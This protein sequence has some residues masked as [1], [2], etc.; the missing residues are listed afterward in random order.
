MAKSAIIIGRPNAGKTLFALQFAEF[1]GVKQWSL[2]RAGEPVDPSERAHL[3]GPF[4]HTTRH[5]QAIGL[6]MRAGKRK[7]ALRLLD[8]AGLTPGIHED[9]SVRAA[10]AVT[11]RHLLGADLVLH[12]FDAAAP[13]P[14][15]EID[16]EVQ[17]GAPGAYAILAN[18][19]DLPGAAEGVRR[20][21]QAFGGR[22]L[23]PISALHKTGFREVAAYV[24]RHL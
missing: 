22:P 3:V 19:I 13:D 23:F 7:A 9:P 18:K 5:V 24:A 17:A 1:L 12:L 15:D 10:Q 14:I 21:R 6:T 8:T 2:E 11:I 20:L 16:R 4:P